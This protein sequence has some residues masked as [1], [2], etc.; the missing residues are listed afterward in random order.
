MA[1]L[2]KNDEGYFSAIDSRV[3]R[4]RLL[5]VPAIGLLAVLLDR[6][7][8]WQI[9]MNELTQSVDLSPEEM[10]RLFSELIEAGFSIAQRDRY[11]VYYD[12]YAYPM[13]RPGGRSFPDKKPVETPA[14]E[15]PSEPPKDETPAPDE[16][17]DALKTE[18]PKSVGMTDEQRAYWV[19]YIRENF[20]RTKG[21]KSPYDRS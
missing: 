16:T 2:K 19:N 10:Q 15:K 17:P 7:R 14:P 9:R 3:I 21:Y 13:H 5:S 18:E 11:G 4:G 1:I 12:I 20:P 8:T 6:P